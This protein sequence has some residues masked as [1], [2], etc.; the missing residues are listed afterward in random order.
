MVSSSENVQQ[1][2]LAAADWTNRQVFATAAICLALG[3]TLG[4]L[5][6]GPRAQNQVRAGT[7]SSQGGRTWPTLPPSANPQPT[8]AERTTV[9][10][11]AAGP[12]LESLKSN[13]RD[14]KLLVMAGEI[15]YRHGAYAEAASYYKRA[16]AVKDSSMLRNQYANALFKNGEVDTALQQYAQVL[17]ADP[18][19]DVALF[20][21]GV[22]KLQSKN[23]SKGAVRMWK[24]LLDVYPNHPHRDEVQDMIDGASRIQ[25]NQ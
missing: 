14:F 16:L 24:K 6:H 12:I 10:S 5:L 20:N 21:S 9:S 4:F 17:K 13:P 19:N 1:P 23:D 15:Y 25:P 18:T 3:V 2:I 7:L 22:I 8:P 11:Q